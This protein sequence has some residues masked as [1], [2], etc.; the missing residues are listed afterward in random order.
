M[1]ATA[2]EPSP[3]GQQDEAGGYSLEGVFPSPPLLLADEPGIR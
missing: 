3:F 2:S 1:A